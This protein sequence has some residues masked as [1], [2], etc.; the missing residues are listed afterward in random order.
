[1]EKKCNSCGVVKDVSNFH[2][3][4]RSLNGYKPRC[5]ECLNKY[6]NDNYHKYKKK[7][8]TQQKEYYKNNQKKIKKRVSEYS[9]KNKE[10][11]SRYQVEYIKNR[12]EIDPYFKFERQIRA[13]ISRLKTN[14]LDFKSKYL[15]FTPKDFLERNGRFPNSKEC[16]DHKI[17]VSWFK[18]GAP[19]NVINSIYNLQVIS[20]K[21]NM[22][23]SNKYSDLVDS[24]Y[25]ESVVNHIKEEFK[26]RINKL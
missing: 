10:K 16:I 22:K 5:K 24:I 1:M 25:Y 7:K 4:S 12:C 3:E 18:D 11:K 23:K 17:P 21:E 14:N 19:C 8:S 6:Y 26:N 9:K 13:H 2:V 20:R 15:D